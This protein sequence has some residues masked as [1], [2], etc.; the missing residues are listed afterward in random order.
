MSLEK[1]ENNYDVSQQNSASKQTYIVF[2]L[3]NG[4]YAAPLLSVREVVEFKE[5]K[6]IPQT[7]DFFLGVTNIRGEIVG[8]LDLSKRLAGVFCSEERRSMLVV[9]VDGCSLAVVVNSVIKVV[10]LSDEEIDKKNPAQSTENSFEG[11]ARVENELITILNLSQTI[12]E[13]DF[14]QL[15]KFSS[16]SSITSQ[17]SSEVA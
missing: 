8:V 2:S 13:K 3:N 1:F 15:K 14:T 17:N 5:P 4:S 12:Q 16:L 11:I 10:D 6:P 9:H 7:Q